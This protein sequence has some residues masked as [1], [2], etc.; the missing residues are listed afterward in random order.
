MSQ[1][2]NDEHS[3]QLNNYVMSGSGAHVNELMHSVENLYC[4]SVTS[5]KRK[6]SVISLPSYLPNF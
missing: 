1:G 2:F 5:M 3:I 4:L 6:H